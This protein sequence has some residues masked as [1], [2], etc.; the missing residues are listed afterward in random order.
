MW[1]VLPTKATLWKLL[2]SLVFPGGS[3][4]CQY[5]NAQECK[6]KI[7]NI[8]VCYVAYCRFK[9][10]LIPDVFLDFYLSY[11]EKEGVPLLLSIQSKTGKTVNCMTLLPLMLWSSLGI[12]SASTRCTL[13]NK[14]ERKE[15]RY[16]PEN[17]E[18]ST[19]GLQSR[20]WSWAGDG[21]IHR[22]DVLLHCP[23]MLHH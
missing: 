4:K 2:Q 16:L 13:A 9:C 23:T 7:K 8:L 5:Q 14:R 10:A 17:G 18:I 1:P 21:S 6:K 19:K 15:N 11:Q 12:L 22:R 3:V 20:L